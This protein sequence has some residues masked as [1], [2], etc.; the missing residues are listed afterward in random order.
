MR[1]TAAYFSFSDS[2]CTVISFWGSV[3]PL[4]LHSVTTFRICFFYF[5]II[6]FFLFPTFKSYWSIP[7]FIP[8][9][10]NK[11]ERS[12][13]ERS[14]KIFLNGLPEKTKQSTNRK[15][16][17]Y[18]FPFCWHFRSTF[19]F[20]CAS[21]CFSRKRQQNQLLTIGKIIRKF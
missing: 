9:V 6:I 17:T 3:F 15:R 8:F 12:F 13:S 19:F 5:Y 14:E 2:V 7:A 20:P 10:I 21:Q 16:A 18:F 1:K 4:L 11:K